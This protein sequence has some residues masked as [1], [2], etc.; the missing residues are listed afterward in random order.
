MLVARHMAR[1]DVKKA[2]MC[3]M[4]Q[5]A[6][7]TSAHVRTCKLNINVPVIFIQIF[8]IKI[9]IWKFKTFDTCTKPLER[10]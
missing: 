1:P 2:G 6:V 4:P 10:P 8:I 9:E 3:H 7:Y 5:F